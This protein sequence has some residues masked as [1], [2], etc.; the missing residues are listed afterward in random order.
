MSTSDSSSSPVSRGASDGEAEGRAAAVR[1][2]FAAGDRGDAEAALATLA[3]D[4]RF[5]FGNAE[6]GRGRDAVRA[7]REQIRSQIARVQHEVRS[8]H[9]DGAGRHATAQLR[10]TYQHRDGRILRVP[11]CAVFDFDAAGLVS[12]YWVY[13]DQEDFWGP[14]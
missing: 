2:Y 5:R 14:L 6:P 3:E 8:V 13:V 1:E 4:V 7:V 11:A 10:M 9:V 12:G